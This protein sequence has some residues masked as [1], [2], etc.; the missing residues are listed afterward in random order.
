[1]TGAASFAS[2]LK[3]VWGD[4]FLEVNFA[5]AASDTAISDT[6][7]NLAS[8]D[9]YNKRSELWYSGKPLLRSGQLKGIGPDLASEMSTCMYRV[10]GGKTFV[11]KK[12]DMKKRTGFSPDIAES[13][14]VCLAVAR[15]RFGLVSNERSKNS[16]KEMSNDQFRQWAE[17]ISG[18]KCKYLEFEG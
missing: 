9:Y 14:W 5:E 10:I 2:L 4:G 16:S 3:M 18:V 15:E 6:D 8:D 7:S 17:Q 1:V 13:A 11:E 12:E